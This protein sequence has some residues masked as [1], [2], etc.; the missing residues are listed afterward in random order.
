[1]NMSCPDVTEEEIGLVL[2]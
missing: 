2:L 1:Y